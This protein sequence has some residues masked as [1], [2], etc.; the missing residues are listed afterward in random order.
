MAYVAPDW[1]NDTSPYINEDNLNAISETLECVPVENGGTGATDAPQARINLGIELPLPVENGGT[2]AATAVQALDNIG[3]EPKANVT[4]KGATDTPV[5]F[6]SNAVAQPIS[7]PIPVSLGGTGVSSLSTLIS[8]MK[9]VTYSSAN[10]G[11]NNKYVYVSNGVVTAS[12]A[13]VGGANQNMYLSGGTFTAGNSF[14]PT[15]GGT[16]SGNVTLNAVSGTAG[17]QGFSVFTLGNSNAKTSANNSRGVLRL[18]T[19][20]S[21][22]TNYKIDVY[23]NATA[24][25]DYFFEDVGGGVV[26]HATGTQVGSTNTPVYI[27]SNGRATVMSSALPASLGGTGATSLS[28]VTVG[29]A[30]KVGTG[31]VGSTAKPVYINA[32]TPT[33]IS[34]NIGSASKPVYI[35]GG[36][37]TAC[38]ST[39][40]SGTKPVYMSGGT[41]TASGS[42]VGSAS[43]P[44]W[45]SS[46]NITAMSSPLAIALGGTGAS[47]ITENSYKGASNKITATT[48]TLGKLVIIHVQALNIDSFNTTASGLIPS[49]KRPTNLGLVCTMNCGVNLSAFARCTVYGNGNIEVLTNFYSTAHEYNG[50]LVYF[51][52]Q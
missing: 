21:S 40:G 16:F 25:R 14:V 18:Y 24:N 27:A 19:G 15:G 32:G 11:A 41:I 20:N 49:G 17:T 4:S 13:T 36:T 30:S 7:A 31:T 22:G 52:A 3:A 6:D 35:S 38:S 48:W 2:G 10:T 51:A 23:A 46:G 45:M 47:S 39:V 50:T 1:H 26:S 9:S 12:S 8:N 33:A 28:S 44:V 34:G 5:Y 42:T 43:V 37:I 29:V